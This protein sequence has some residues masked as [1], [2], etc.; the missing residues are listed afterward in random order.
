MTKERFAEI[1][2]EY[3]VTSDEIDRAIGI[4]ITLLEEEI[5]DLEQAEYDTNHVDIAADEVAALCEYI[6]EVM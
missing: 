1:K 5:I 3:G 2:K 6:E 4:V